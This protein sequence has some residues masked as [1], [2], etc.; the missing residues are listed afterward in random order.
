[1][2]NQVL[3]TLIL[4]LFWMDGRRLPLL[5]NHPLRFYQLNF[6]ETADKGL[7]HVDA[8]GR[9]RAIALAQQETVSMAQVI[10]AQ[11]LEQQRQMELLQAKTAKEKEVSGTPKPVAS[12]LYMISGPL[13][14][15]C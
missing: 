2:N 14:P 12:R 1:M 7:R 6:L 5:P 4:P 3:W 9:T 10:K 13:V 15:C 11:R 8:L